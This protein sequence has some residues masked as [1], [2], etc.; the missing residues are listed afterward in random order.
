MLSQVPNILTML[1]IA[2][3]PALVLLLRDSSYD[4]ALIL[5]FVAGITDGLDGYIAKKFNCA[6]QLGAILDPI[7]DKVLIASAY[8]MLAILQDIPFWLL[9]VVMFR[10]LVIV[11]GFL[12]LVALRNDVKMT[13]TY[14][15]KINTFLQIAL[16]VVVLVEKVN[17]LTIPMFVDVLIFGVLITTVVSGVQ[18]VW[19]WGIKQEK[20]DNPFPDG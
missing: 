14:V 1:R 8:I 18:Y 5:F 10:D 19:L 13:P 12:V 6:S 11:V 20:V 9:I 2:I 3:C 7:A 17:W 16:M 15:S 4:L